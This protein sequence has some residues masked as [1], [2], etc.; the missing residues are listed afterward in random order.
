MEDKPFF[1]VLLERAARD[2]PLFRRVAE[3]VGAKGI[4]PRTAVLADFFEDDKSFYFG[5]LTTPA[6]QVFQ[7]GYDYRD[8]DPTEGVATPFWGPDSP[9]FALPPDFGA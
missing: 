4:D 9:E 5:L 8:A 7:F 3:L 6:G 2:E 1:P